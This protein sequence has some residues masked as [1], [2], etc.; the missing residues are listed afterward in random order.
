MKRRL[1]KLVV[2]LILGAI[3]TVAVAWGCANWMEIDHL[4]FAM[5]DNVLVGASQIDEPSPFW[6]IAYLK[7]RGLG[8]VISSQDNFEVW[9]NRQ[10][11]EVALPHWSRLQVPS[12]EW[13]KTNI[14][15]EQETASG[16][17]MYAMSWTARH[18]LYVSLDRRSIRSDVIYGLEIEPP[19]SFGESQRALPL[20]P[21]WRGF[22][23][24]TVFYAAI[25]WLLTLGPSAA[26]R[27][28]R[29]R[30]GHCLNCGY[31]LRGDFSAGCPE[32]GWRREDVP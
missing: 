23:I 14:I 16:W 8:R 3:A 13:K 15:D 17:P 26:R 10:T 7:Q 6:S 22:A 20:H 12:R 28:I 4:P 27:T 1:F 29:R 25:L 24:N 32:C 21:L 18:S 9:A 5:A 31:D 11:A 30:R 2:F 19:G